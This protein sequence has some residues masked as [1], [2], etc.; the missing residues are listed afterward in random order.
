MPK[1]PKISKYK[2][3]PLLEKMFENEI[4]YSFRVPSS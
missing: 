1:M 2:I 4:I 3:M